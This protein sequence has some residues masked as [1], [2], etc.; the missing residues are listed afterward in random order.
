MFVRVLGMRSFTVVTAVHGRSRSQGARCA[1]PQGLAWMGVVRVEICVA[2]PWGLV[3]G[4]SCP[5][6]CAFRIGLYRGCLVAVSPRCVVG[7]GRRLVVSD[8]LCRWD[9]RGGRRV[10]V[11]WNLC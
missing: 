9:W 3:V 7:I 1:V 11:L 8:V 2:L 10:V 6:R 5:I 4:A